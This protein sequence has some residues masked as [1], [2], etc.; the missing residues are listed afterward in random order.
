MLDRIIQSL[1]EDKVCGNLTEELFKKMTEA[2]EA[3]LTPATVR[4]FIDHI[5]VHEAEKTDGKKRQIV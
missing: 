4:E 3:E 1:Y 2:Y 5:I